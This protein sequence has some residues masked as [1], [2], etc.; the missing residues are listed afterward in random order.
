MMKFTSFTGKSVQQVKLL[1]C[2]LRLVR[3]SFV[4][5]TLRLGI[6]DIQ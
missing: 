3:R 6:T 1:Q 4:A 2:D 5:P